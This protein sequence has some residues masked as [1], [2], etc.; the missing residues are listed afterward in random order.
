MEFRIALEST[1]QGGFNRF[2]SLVYKRGCV[3]VILRQKKMC[4]AEMNV[5]CLRARIGLISQCADD[6]LIRSATGIFTYEFNIF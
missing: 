4:K 6:F 2:S 3:Y 1:F 5:L